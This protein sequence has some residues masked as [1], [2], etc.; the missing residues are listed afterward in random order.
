MAI[1]FILVKKNTKRYWGNFKS[2]WISFTKHQSYYWTLMVKKIGL[3]YQQKEIKEKNKRNYKAK[4]GKG[5][6]DRF[7]PLYSL[8]KQWLKSMQ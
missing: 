5:F 4:R 1:E 8:G 3:V 6:G 2:S 7:N